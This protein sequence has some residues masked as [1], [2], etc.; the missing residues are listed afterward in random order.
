MSCTGCKYISNKKCGKMVKVQ[1]ASSGARWEK[2]PD[3]RCKANK[4]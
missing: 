2:V 1:V 3:K 4:K